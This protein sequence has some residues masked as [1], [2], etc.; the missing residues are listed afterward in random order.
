[1]HV[2]NFE[3]GDDQRRPSTSEGAYLGIANA[4]SKVE[5]VVGLIDREV[6]P[7][8]DLIAGDDQD[9][10]S[11]DR[12]DRHDGHGTVVGVDEHAR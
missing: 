3:S 12:V 11:V 7:A 8:I 5:Q 10:P 9:M 2:G 4:L 1:M 6:G